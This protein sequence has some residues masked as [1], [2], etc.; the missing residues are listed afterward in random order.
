[1]G[2][3][4]PSDGAFLAV[5]NPSSHETAHHRLAQ[6]LALCVPQDQLG[7]ATLGDRNRRLT[8][9]HPDWIG[10]PMQAQVTCRC[11]EV[12]SFDLPCPALR[13]LPLAAGKRVQ[14]ANQVF[15]LPCMADLGLDG[16]VGP[17]TDAPLPMALVYACRVDGQG[18]LT[19]DQ[20]QK[21]ETLWSGADPGAVAE[22]Y[23]PCAA[24][25]FQIAA[26]ADLAEFVARDLDQRWRGLLR[27][28]DTIARAY[29]WG[30]ADILGLPEWRHR[31]Y[32]A[33]IL[34]PQV[35]ALPERQRARR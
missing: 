11:G 25:G 16:R 14:L 30:E 10:R 24:C 5:W 23:L 33:L 2:T 7:A 21:V 18:S 1:M 34:G 32:L 15:R 17:L 13:A 22:M 4:L 9:L 28:V 29:G 12:H 19:T 35:E 26:A 20:V 27:T 8:G 31:A 3:P 6:L